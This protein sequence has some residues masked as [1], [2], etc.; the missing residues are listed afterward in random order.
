VTVGSIAAIKQGMSFTAPRGTTVIIGLPPVGQE[1]CFS[2]LEIIPVEKNII[3][4]FMGAANLKVDIPR[5]VS[6]YQNGRLKLDELITG[7]YPLE[8]INEAV[9]STEKGEGLRNVIMFE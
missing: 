2:P 8:R 9:A 6:M 7:R 4:G 1:L 5:L 3:G